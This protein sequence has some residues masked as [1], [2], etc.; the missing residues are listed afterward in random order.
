MRQEIRH[1]QERPSQVWPVVRPDIDIHLPTH[2]PG[3]IARSNIALARERTEIRTHQGSQATDSTRLTG[4]PCRA[5]PQDAELFLTGDVM[6]A[7]MENEIEKT[8]GVSQDEMVQGT[9]QRAAK[10]G[11]W[12]GVHTGCGI[13]QTAGSHVS[14]SMRARWI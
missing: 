12:T 14:S 5:L 13:R 6:L 3:T 4:G 10:S 2:V 8:W 7:E 11:D 9:G 1:P